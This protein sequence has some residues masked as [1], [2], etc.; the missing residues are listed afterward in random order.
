[1]VVQ[2]CSRNQGWRNVVEMLT[3]NV[4]E[5]SGAKPSSS[6]VLEP[7]SVGEALKQESSQV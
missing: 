7:K 1:M 2:K 5:N 4:V 6:S 3:A